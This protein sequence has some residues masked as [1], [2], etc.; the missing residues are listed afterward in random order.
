MAVTKVKYTKKTKDPVTGEVLKSKTYYKYKVEVRLPNG[1]RT[2]KTFATKTAADTYHAQVISGRS[3]GTFQPPPPRSTPPFDIYARKIVAAHR[4]KEGTSDRYTSDLEAHL[5]P[6]FGST[7]IGKI[8]TEMAQE[9]VAEFRN[10]LTKEPL[11]RSTVKVVKASL[12]VVLKQAVEDGYLRTLPNLSLPR[13]ISDVVPDEDDDCDEDP[14]H[15]EIEQVH[16]LLDVSGPYWGPMYDF[17]VRTGLRQGELFA[18]G[19]KRSRIV[20]TG[21]NP[22]YRVREQVRLPKKGGPRLAT[23]KS[24]N[25]LRDIPLDPEAVEILSRLMHDVPEGPFWVS[26]HGNLLRRQHVNANWKR[27]LTWA[28]LDT[29]FGMHALRHTNASVL[30]AGGADVKTVQELLGHD[31][32]ATTL[33]TYAHLMNSQRHLAR[34]IMSSALQ[35]PALTVVA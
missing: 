34:S 35:R 11:A 4:V 5:I 10:R 26:K 16:A 24:K 28:G 19:A 2:A 18:V 33:K 12:S 29:G 25:S 17:G 27:R 31:S 13:D 23:P 32:V 3:T 21:P 22:V 20:L 6:A 15:L 8:D 14:R 7:P 9:A 1:K 30:I